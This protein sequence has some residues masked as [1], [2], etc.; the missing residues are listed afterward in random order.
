MRY[1]FLILCLL[2]CLAASTSGCATM[3]NE[4]KRAIQYTPK[5]K[6]SFDLS[7]GSNAGI[8]VIQARPPSEQVLIKNYAIVVD[9]NEPIEVFKHSDTDIIL[10]VGKYTVKLYAS[11]SKGTKWL[12]GETFG[13]VTT[14]EINIEKD[15][16]LIFEYTGPYWMGNE[17]KLE[18]KLR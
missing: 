16:T 1:K 12:Y 6:Y 17:G 8:L 3:F 10:D 4:K 13:K 14:E 11:S 2:L 9:D 18:E 15:K 5:G 7:S